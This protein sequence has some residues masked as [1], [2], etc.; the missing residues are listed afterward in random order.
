MRSESLG[1]KA[2]RG[3]AAGIGLASEAYKANKREKEGKGVN[4]PSE[5]TTGV[6]RLAD[7]HLE[8]EWNLDEAQ[9]ELHAQQEAQNQ[10]HRN[11][12]QEQEQH[13]DTNDPE[14]E[15]KEYTVEAFLRNVQRAPPPYTADPSISPKLVYP[16]ILPQRRPKSNKRG[17]IRAYAPDLEQFGIDQQMF[18]D[19][20]ETSNKACQAT[21]WLYALNLASI[22]TIWLPSALSF[23][24]STMIQLGTEAAIM[25]E[26]RRK[27]N[28]FFDKINAEF[29]RPRGLFCLV[30]T[31]QPES[32]STFCRFDLNTAI[33][34]AVEH[35]GPGMLNKLKHTFKSS[36]GATQGNIAFP[37][38]AP[39]IF[40]EL[41]ALAATGS[42]SQVKKLSRKDFVTDYFDRRGQA[43]FRYENPDSGLNL[44]P[45]P[46]F[47]S[48]YADPSHPASSGDLLGLVTGGHLTQDKLPRRRP[49]LSTPVHNGRFANIPGGNIGLRNIPGGGIIRAIAERTGALPAQGQRRDEY[50]SGYEHGYEHGYGRNGYSE[51]AYH[52]GTPAAPYAEQTGVRGRDASLV[53]RASQFKREGPL[54]NGVIGGVKKLLESNV[55]YLMIVN[56]PS[57][58]EMAAA[59]EMMA[60]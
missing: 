48:R 11:Q 59:R 30:M 12:N 22:G 9:D 23:I 43:R 7:T 58:E 13:S 37:Q 33:S 4:G 5:Q 41:D 2:V 25:A 52:D 18:L 49:P 24:V 31:W 17:F 42:D 29:F 6:E 47:T 32:A 56:M 38:T 15:S 54:A 28:S 50:G 40:P 26:E 20:I 53:G 44:S 45:K 8:E 14:E 55:V 19:F 16:V 46:S 51:Y 35:G 34:S 57:A 39:L 1:S 60:R 3:L 36:N 21:P 27:T 10:D